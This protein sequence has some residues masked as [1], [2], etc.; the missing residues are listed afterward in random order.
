MIYLL[1]TNILIYL[2]K[3]QPPELAQR[4]GNHQA[5]AR[6]RLEGQDAR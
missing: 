1:D 5:A 2:I 3:N 4:V 6:Q